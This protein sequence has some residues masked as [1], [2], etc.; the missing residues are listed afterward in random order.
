MFLFWLAVPV[1]L[2]FL[3]GAQMTAA[4]SDRHEQ[5][6]VWPFPTLDGRAPVIIAHRGASGYLPEHTLEAY[7]LAIELGADFIEPDLVMTRDGHFVVRHD[8]YLST[9]TNIAEHPEFGNRRRNDGKREDWFVEDFTLAEI[10]TLRARQAYPGRSRAFD[11]MLEIPTLQEVI[12]LAK[13]ESARRG[14]EV[15]IYPELKHPAHFAEIGLDPA[16]SLVETLKRNGY[17]DRTAAVYIQSF[18]AGVLRRLNRMTNLPLVMLVFSK[19]QTDETADAGT[20]SVALEQAA[21]FADAVGPDKDLLVGMDGR[22]TGFLGRAHQ[23]G[24]AVHPWTVRDDNIAAYVTS[25]P[26]EYRRL[27]EMGVDGL[28]TDFSDTAVS[29]RAVLA[30][31]SMLQQDRD[32]QSHGPADHDQAGKNE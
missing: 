23:L 29:V 10:K 28:F 18:E 24:L 12:D 7:A 32:D 16:A 9:T 25:A 1:P 20:P 19:D 2:L 22:D 31:Q 15:G 5:G 14:R 8:R 21:E 3:L 11:D 17:E 27:F 26:A 6:K 13:T 30:A 4:T